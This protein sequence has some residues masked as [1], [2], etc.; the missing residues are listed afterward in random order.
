MYLDRVRS[1]YQN[2]ARQNP[3][4]FTLR[5]FE[6]DPENIDIAVQQTKDKNEGAIEVAELSRSFDRRYTELPIGETRW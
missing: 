3:N 5:S 1:R 2:P 4:C 6:Y